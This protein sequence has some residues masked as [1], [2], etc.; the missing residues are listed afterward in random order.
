MLIA[1]IQNLGEYPCP[2]CLIPKSQ[3]ELVATSHDMLRR[4]LL[5]RSD[6]KERK[7]K[8]SLAR[9]LIYQ[10]NYAVDS[11]QVQR[12]LKNES[13]VPTTICCDLV[14]HTED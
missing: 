14:T 3:I 11:A 2:C 9:N 1:N 10:Q 5:S 13:L 7:D 12:V 4:E 6:S 8:I